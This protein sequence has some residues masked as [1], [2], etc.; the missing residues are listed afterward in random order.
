MNRKFFL[1]IPGMIFFWCLMFANLQYTHAA[2]EF[3]EVQKDQTP[4]YDSRKGDLETV[5]YLTKGQRFKVKKDYGV[6]WWQIDFG[7][8]DAYIVKGNVFPIA[9][10]NYINGNKKYT[11]SSTKITMKV[12]APV[13]DNTTGKLVQFAVIKEGQNYPVISISGNWY[14][15]DIDGRLGYIHN[16]QAN[17]VK[18]ESTD[19]VPNTPAATTKIYIKANKDTPLYDNRRGYLDEIGKLVKGQQL[20]IVKQEGANWWQ[21]KWANSYAYLSKA[22]VEQVKTINYKNSSSAYKSTNKNIVPLYDN[23]PVYDNTSGSLVQFATLKE[24]HRY[25]YIMKSGNWF[26][27]DIGGRYGYVHSSSVK[28]D[29]GISILMYHHILD[30]KDLGVYKGVS[31]TITSEQFSKE[32]EYLH[33]QSFE[34]VSMDDLEK[35]VKGKINL[36]AKATVI[37]FDD[38]LVSVRENAYPILR[39]YGM[40]ATEYVIT[41]RNNHPTELFNPKKLQFFSNEDIKNMGDVFVYQAHTHNLHNLD[42]HNKSDVITKSL[43]VVEADIRLNK[44]ILHANSF[45]YPFGH[46]NDNTIMLLKKLG[47]KSAVTTIRGPVNVGDDV[48][49]LKRYGIYQ[50]TSLSEFIEIVES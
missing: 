34:T 37:T 26:M 4:V 50:S 10:A 47:F 6:N 5:G 42:I 11:N 35:Y 44:S 3:V 19:P 48:L 38:G 29:K 8:Y 40:K 15:V 46:Y 36:P 1:V 33:K 17:L 2:T 23:I 14:L 32:M 18:P 20:E 9:S 30:E 43:A 7:G 16:A 28:L 49:Q 31:T 25:P 45:A 27:L 12:D 24:N 13:Y 21:V 22:S 41:S 39:Q